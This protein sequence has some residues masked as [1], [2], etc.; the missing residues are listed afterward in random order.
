MPNQTV[1]TF[2][3]AIF[4]AYEDDGPETLAGLI[5]EGE[6]SLKR[7]YVFPDWEYAQEFQA[8]LDKWGNGRKNPRITGFYNNDLY[9]QSVPG[10]S[11][12]KVISPSFLAV[13]EPIIETEKGAS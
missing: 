7:L 5:K 6:H 2:E 11:P 9:A 8:G 3:Q 1:Q 12:L 4:A 10:V 13:I